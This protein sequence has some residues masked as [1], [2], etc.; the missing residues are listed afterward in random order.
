VRDVESAET[1]RLVAAKRTAS[2]HQRPRM[3]L[4]Q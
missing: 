1:A 2:P 3:A 4:P